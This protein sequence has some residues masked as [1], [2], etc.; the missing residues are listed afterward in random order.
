M[1]GPAREKIWDPATLD[2]MRC[3]GDPPADDAVHEML[4]AVDGSPE[5]TARILLRQLLGGGHHAALLGCPGSALLAEFLK[6][7]RQLPS[8]TNH[9]LLLQAQHL[10]RNNLVTG[11]VLLAVASLP[12]CYLDKRGAPVLAATGQ[13]SGQPTRR[14]RHTAHMVFSVSAPGGL[15]VQP[16]EPPGTVPVGVSKALTV[17][18]T[19]STVA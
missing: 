11:S 13:L 1:N 17:R 9:D 4:K 6:E 3:E 7:H 10:C 2:E 14:L 15:Q 16:W 5:E 8:W 19:P 12:E 18:L